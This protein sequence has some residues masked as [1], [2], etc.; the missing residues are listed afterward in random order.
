M[1]ASVVSHTR[2]APA[3]RTKTSRGLYPVFPE[4]SETARTPLTMLIGLVVLAL[5][6]LAVNLFINTQM[7]QLAYDIRSK[8]SELA[9]LSDEGEALRQDIQ[10][11]SSPEHLREAAKKAGLVPVGASGFITLSDKSVEGGTPAR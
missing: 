3:S 7:V 1:S 8:Q 2:P 9:V 4:R 5:V 6:I 10:R 11:L